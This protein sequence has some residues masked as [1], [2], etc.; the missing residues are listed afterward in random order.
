MVCVGE[1]CLSATGGVTVAGWVGGS[2]GGIYNQ[3]QAYDIKN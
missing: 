1:S 2:P 3:T